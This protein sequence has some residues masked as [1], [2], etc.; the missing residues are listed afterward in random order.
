M[1]FVA[2]FVV[3][4]GTIHA[5]V[6]LKDGADS[7]PESID[8]V[9]NYLTTLETT[10]QLFKTNGDNMRACSD[11]SPAEDPTGD[12]NT[13]KSQFANDVE[14][15]HTVIMDTGLTKITKDLDGE[16][17][18]IADL[19]KTIIDA[20]VAGTILVWLVVV[21]F[22]VA[23]LCKKRSCL[24][25]TSKVLAFPIFILMTAVLGACLMSSVT[26]A[27]FC[28]G[29]PRAFLT[30][31][32]I[33]QDS[34]DG[35]DFV[36]YYFNCKGQSP[37][38]N[39]WDAVQ[40]SL[41]DLKNKLKGKVLS[42]AIRCMETQITVGSANLVALEGDLDCSLFSSYLGILIDEAV[43]TDFVEGLFYSWC[44]SSSSSLLLG[45]L[46]RA[47]WLRAISLLC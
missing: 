44:L 38:K 22:A 30:D 10:A 42:P 7:L 34:A 1:G 9:S 39:D 37:F 33:K 35:Q 16:G 21:L 24:Y 15:V 23:G 29:D 45:A 28:V 40:T 43:C 11:L 41:S 2:I 14:Q 26:M 13:A 46:C 12:I 25:T 20:S 36:N 18:D 6:K 27:D 17:D 32:L 4:L 3:L 47:H 5:S 19:M 31:E 8:G